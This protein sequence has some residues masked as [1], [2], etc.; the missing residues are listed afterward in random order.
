[1]QNEIHLRQNLVWNVGVRYDLQFLADPVATDTNNIAPRI[2][3]AWDPWNDGKT[4]VRASYGIYN[5]RIPLRALSNALQ[6]DGVNYRIALLSRSASGAPAFPNVL[7]GYP[8][9]L[10]SNITTIDPEIG[11]GYS[12]QVNVQVERELSPSFSANVGYTHL[13]GTDLIM[14]RN[15]NVPTTTN[16]AVFNLGRPDPNF[17]NNGQFQSIGDSWYDGLTVALNKRPG[18][19]GSVRVSYTYSKALDTAGNFFFSTPQDNFDIAAE[20]GSSDNDQ[21][22][23]LVLSGT[24]ESPRHGQGWAS[25]VWRDWL[26]SYVY[27]FSSALPFNIQ[28]GN[29]R[30]GDTNTND[31]PAGV[32]RNT[33]E[34]FGFQS[35]DLRLGRTLRFGDRLQLAASID[36]FNVFNQR[37]DQVPNNVFGTGAFPV[38]PRPGFGAPTAVGDPRQLQLGLRLRF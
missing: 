6:R 31:R 27:S 20:K 9:G 12:H 30:N 26:L 28:T 34:G 4:V 35:F 21:R 1:V 8:S 11:N 24:L 36:A 22:H 29:D 37:N 2:G 23:R 32:G 15:V 7:A 25:H 5:D 33:G 19:F 10:L 3:I 17:A 13:R 16:P 14:S 38:A 18:R